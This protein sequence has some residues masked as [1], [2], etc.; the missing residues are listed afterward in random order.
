MD[1]RGS[2]WLWLFGKYCPSYRLL[3]FKGVN[4]YEVL[5]GLN[6]SSSLFSSLPLSPHSAQPLGPSFT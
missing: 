1:M 5:H 6:L 4:G 3:Q 2:K